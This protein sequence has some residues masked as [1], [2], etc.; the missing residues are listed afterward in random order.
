ME[1]P[2]TFQRY[3]ALQE[4]FK[5]SQTA[6]QQEPGRRSSAWNFRAVKFTGE[7]KHGKAIKTIK[8]AKPIN[9]KHKIWRARIY[10]LQESHPIVFFALVDFPAESTSPVQLPIDVCLGTME[11]EGQQG[12]CGVVGKNCPWMPKDSSYLIY[13]LVQSRGF[14]F[15]SHLLSSNIEGANFHM[16]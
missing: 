8:T 5:F 7:I 10:Q 1:C 12:S 14:P 3:R 16:H 6:A 4:L 11:G 9:P 13:W 15:C 2:C